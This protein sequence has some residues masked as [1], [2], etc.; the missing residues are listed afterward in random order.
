[1]VHVVLVGH[2][3]NTP[4][5]QI[6]WSGGGLLWVLTLT[7]VR[8]IKPIL[9]LRQPYE[10]V[11]VIPKRG[12]TYT[13]EVKPVGHRGMQ[14]SP[15]QFAWLTIWNSPFSDTEH[16]FSISSSAGRTNCLS[17]TIKEFGDFTRQ[18][19]TL[20][21]GQRL[22]VDGPYGAFSTD[23]HRHAKGFALIAGRIALK[24][25]LPQI[26]VWWGDFHS[27]RFNLV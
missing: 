27:E 6:L 3:I 25:I 4:F 19:K 9:L 8:I 21:P 20:Q 10:V 15:G 16:P 14:F 2:Y 7:W 22:Y 1:M 18:I 11:R 24:I 5:K 26:G 23:R 13:L 12:N 17:F